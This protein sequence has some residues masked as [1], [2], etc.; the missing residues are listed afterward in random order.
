MVSLYDYAN[1][2]EKAAARLDAATDPNAALDA[3]SALRALTDDTEMMLLLAESFRLL[4]DLLPTKPGG[5]HE[6]EQ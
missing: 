2:I 4:V 3:L 6:N 1:R 5:E